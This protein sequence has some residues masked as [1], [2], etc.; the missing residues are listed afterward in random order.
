MACLASVHRALSFPFWG[1]C[2]SPSMLQGHGHQ[3]GQLISRHN[4]PDNGQPLAEGHPFF[5][6]FHSKHIALLTKTAVA[7]A[8]LGREVVCAGEAREPL[9]YSFVTI[10]WSHIVL[11]QILTL[12]RKLCNLSQVIS[13]SHTFLIV[14]TR[15]IKP[16]GHSWCED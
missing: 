6:W 15:R 10:I 8:F 11:V 2:L 9:D 16:T 13:L 1:L 7:A 5:H 14:K 3:A 12:L 4:G